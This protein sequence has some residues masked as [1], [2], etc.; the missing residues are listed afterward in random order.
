MLCVGL[1]RWLKCWFLTAKIMIFDC[2]CKKNIQRFYHQRVVPTSKQ[3][4]QDLYPDFFCPEK[5][6]E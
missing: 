3:I 1:K 2:I 4:Y 6:N 5:T